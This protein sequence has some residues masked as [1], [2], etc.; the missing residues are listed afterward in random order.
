MQLT[1]GIPESCLR[2]TAG[3]AV[4]LA[5]VVFQYGTIAL[6]GIGLCLM[7]TF[8]SGA[9]ICAAAMLMLW[10]C[11]GK[12]RLGKMLDWVDRASSFTLP[13]IYLAASTAS[14]IYFY[15]YLG[16]HHG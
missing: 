10:I 1:D 14:G 7:A 8:V 11:F 9:V 16:P 13:L 2:I 4:L 6:L 3:V 5:A 12:A 15:N